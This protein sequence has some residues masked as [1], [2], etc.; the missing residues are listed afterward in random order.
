MDR[1]SMHSKGKLLL[2]RHARCAD[3][4]AD[5]ASLELAQVELEH[6]YFVGKASLFKVRPFARFLTSFA[7]IV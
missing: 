5:L 1:R 7:I 3:Q 2:C 4:T 6:F